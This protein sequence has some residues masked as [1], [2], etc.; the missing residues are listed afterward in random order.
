MKSWLRLALVTMTVGGGFAG[1]LSTLQPLFHSSGVSTT[2]FVLT[3]LFMG[4]YAS[5]TASGLLFVHDP[6]RNGPL[7]IALMLQVPCISSSLIVYRFAAGFDMCAA[8]GSTENASRVDAGFFW[9]FMLGSRWRCVFG[10]ES[11]LR[12]GVNVA[13]LALLLLLWR[14]RQPASQLI[15]SVSDPASESPANPY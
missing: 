4:L 15:P 14:A 1:F 9:D 6:A 3:V 8:V 2:N 13:A 11:P 5:V 7:V 10:Q 12:I